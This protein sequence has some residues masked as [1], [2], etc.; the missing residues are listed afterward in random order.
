VPV[1]S[2]KE[3]IKVAFSEEKLYELAALLVRQ[4]GTDSERFGLRFGLYPM[5]V[6]EKAKELLEQ[7]SA[8]GELGSSGSSAKEGGESD[9]EAGHGRER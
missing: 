1:T 3:V 7:E 2:S 6:V 5:W 4:A 8:S 9:G